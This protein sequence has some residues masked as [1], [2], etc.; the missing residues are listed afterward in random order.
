MGRALIIGCGGVAGVVIHKCCQNSDVFE[1]IMIASRTKSKCDAIKEKLDGTTATKIRTAKVDADNVD[2][3]CALIDEYKPDIVMNI[4]LPYQDLTIMDACLKCGV[5]YMDTANY[6]PEDT[7]DPEWRAIYEKR[8][9][10]EGFTAY[11]DYSWQWAYKKKFEEAGLTALLGSGFDPGVTQAYCAY[12][13][14]HLFDEIDTIDILDCNGGDHGY[15]FATNFNPE[16]NL[17]EVSAPGSYWENGHWVEIPAMS[18]KREYDFD[19]VG[20]KDMYLLHHEEIESLADRLPRLD[21]CVNNAGIMKLVLTPF[22]TTEIIERIQKINLIAPMMLTRN[23]IKKKK[24]KNPSSIVFTASA[25]GV[26]RVSAGNGIYATTKCGIDA[27]M[28]TTALELGGKGIRCN[29]VNPG[30]VETNLIRSGQL[31]GEQLEKDKKNYPLGRYGQPSDIAYAIVYL[32]SD[33]SSWMTGTA[34]KID[35]G[36]TLA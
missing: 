32:L 21:G 30:M 28:R 13:Q 16:I 22:L 20:H 3:L 14:K 33:A 27:F 23:L 4:A 8:C 10:D 19:Q 36:M 25:G 5:N 12:A 11:F 31:S 9:K 34:L 6:E 29:S 17:R 15:P 24:M 2:E 1:E 18:I 35:G 7:D 26:F